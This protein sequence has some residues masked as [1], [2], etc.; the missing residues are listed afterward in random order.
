MAFAPPYAP[1][2]ELICTSDAEVGVIATAVG[3]DDAGG[4][5]GG[6]IDGA[7]VALSRMAT[8]A[9]DMYPA[10]A[11]LTVTHSYPVR[12]PQLT[13]VVSLLAA[14]LVPHCWVNCPAD[15]PTNTPNCPSRSVVALSRRFVT[16]TSP[17]ATEAGTLKETQPMPVPSVTITLSRFPS[18][19]FAFP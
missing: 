17:I 2:T 14:T 6:E 13:V 11:F 7:T 4:G 9:S 1:S 3:V 10:E 5:G 16:S 12:P 19:A 18:I 15:D 8:S